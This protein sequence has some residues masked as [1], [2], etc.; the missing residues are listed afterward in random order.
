MKRNIEKAWE[1]LKETVDILSLKV[2]QSELFTLREACK[3][4][5][6]SIFEIGPEKWKQPMCG[7][8]PIVK[9]GKPL[10]TEEIILEWSSVVS[11][12]ISVIANYYHDLLNSKDSN[13]SNGVLC[14]MIN[15]IVRN[16]LPDYLVDVIDI[17][18]HAKEMITA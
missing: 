14:E 4:T 18:V 3:Y 5:G 17:F 6:E 16:E 7:F 1:G 2:N 13:I 8:S 10:W 12:H 15:Q 11:C 9:N